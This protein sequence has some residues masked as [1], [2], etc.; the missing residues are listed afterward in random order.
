MRTNHWH[1]VPTASYTL[2]RLEDAVTPTKT[3]TPIAWQPPERPEWVRRLN[4]EGDCMDIRGVVP[5]DE[6]SLLDSARHVT[7]LSDF[8][9]LAWLDSFRV[10]IKAL[11]EEAN[12]NLM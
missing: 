11:E 9:D 7:G 10:Y 3:N 4:E 2:Q 8:G 12:L 5:L 1:G 6:A